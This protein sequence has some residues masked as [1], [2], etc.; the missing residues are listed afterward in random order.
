[1]SNSVPWFGKPFRPFKDT[2]YWH[3]LLYTVSLTFQIS[4]L[5]F[6]VRTK[7][8]SWF[9]VQNIYLPFSWRAI[10]TLLRLKY[11]SSAH[12]RLAKTSFFLELMPC[13]SLDGYQHFGGP[14]CL[15]IQ[16]ETAGFPGY[17]NTYEYDSKHEMKTNKQGSWQWGSSSLLMTSLCNA[18]LGWFMNVPHYMKEKQTKQVHR[19]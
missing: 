4:R 10:Q 17:S 3:N 5:L 13:T 9:F 15:Q 1:M 2:R 8:S 16:A 11:N 14:C 18:T 7:F 6:Q 12:E 19:D